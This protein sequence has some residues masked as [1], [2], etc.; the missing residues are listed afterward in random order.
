M[1]DYKSR[2][3][4]EF[5]QNS[6]SSQS[7]SKETYNRNYLNSST[8]YKNLEKELLERYEGYDFSDF[9][10]VKEI[11]TDY[12]N[13]L[14]ITNKYDINFKLKRNNIDNQLI[15]NLKLVSGIGPVKEEKLKNK[16]I[17]NL[18]DLRKIDKYEKEADKILKTIND[19][20][21]KELYNYLENNG[22]FKDSNPMMCAAYTDIENYK[23]MDIE[24]L[25]LSN[26]PI[27]LI[28]IASIKN[29]K[30]TVKQYLQRDGLEEAAIISGYLSNLDDDSIHVSYNGKS[31]DIP[32]I[33][34]RANYFGIKYNKHINYDLLYYTR[35]MYKDILENCK[36]PTVESYICGFERFNDVPGQYI[37]GY[38]KD[39]VS[40][41]NIGPLI[42]IVR[43]NR[44]DV[45]SLADFFMRIYNDINF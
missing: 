32:Y 5:F 10:G 45:K 18:K 30:I 20:E 44:L 9:K 8:Y 24:T 35:Q 4:E 28:G 17:N 14:E 36:L 13:S 40:T 25:G 38:Y 15:N 42:P 43:H 2:V 41:K 7:P 16:G 6:L 11:N 29:N 27:I 33:K 39:Y 3:L 34:N 19:G 26:V 1:S 37:P 31:F 12:G 22:K 21:F 23:F